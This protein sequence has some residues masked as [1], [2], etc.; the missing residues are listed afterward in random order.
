MYEAKTGIMQKDPRFTLRSKY[1]RCEEVDKSR[2]EFHAKQGL[3][4]ADTN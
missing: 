4:S 1:L 2:L 3:Y